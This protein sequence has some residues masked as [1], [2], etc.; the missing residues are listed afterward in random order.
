MVGAI[1]DDYNGDGNDDGDDFDDD[2]EDVDKAHDDVEFGGH[3]DTISACFADGIH[4]NVVRD[5]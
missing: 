4:N 2:Y 3:C 1:V 5:L